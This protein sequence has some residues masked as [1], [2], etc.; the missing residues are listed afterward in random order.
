MANAL[1]IDCIIISSND[2]GD[3]KLRL[4]NDE[5]SAVLSCLPDRVDQ[6]TL[7]SVVD[8]ITTVQSE[9]GG[10]RSSAQ[11]ID[12]LRFACPLLE[13]VDELVK[14]WTRANSRLFLFYGHCARAYFAYLSNY[15]EVG[16]L[17][18]K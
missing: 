13:H 4:T 1:W 10:I 2:S 12:R 9:D 5:L 8:I 16:F 6:L 11:L 15:A 14:I 7:R 17:N 18:Q 3:E